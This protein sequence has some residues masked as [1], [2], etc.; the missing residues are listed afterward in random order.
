MCAQTLA[1]SKARFVSISCRPRTPASTEALPGH[2]TR[3]TRVVRFGLNDAA[4]RTAAGVLTRTAH[5]DGPS[6][7]TLSM[8]KR[9]CHQ[10]RGNKHGRNRASFVRSTTDQFFNFNT[11]HGARQRQRGWGLT[12]ATVRS[13][14]R[15]RSRTDCTRISQRPQTDLRFHGRVG[16]LY[17]IGMTTAVA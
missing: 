9:F 5:P 10:E 15:K 11:P 8:G 16:Y 4:G 17:A 7:T 6:T 2:L 13:R 1:D 12:T 3:H 14:L